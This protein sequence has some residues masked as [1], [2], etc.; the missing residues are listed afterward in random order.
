MRE[1]IEK[2]LDKKDAE[3]VLKAVD[4]VIESFGHPN[5]KNKT[6]GDWRISLPYQMDDYRPDDALSYIH[7]KEMLKSGAIRFVLEM[8]RAQIISPFRNKRSTQVVCEDEELQQLI[9]K[10]LERILPQ[11]M[12]EASWSSL[13]YGSAFMEKVWENKTKKYMGLGDDTTYVTVPKVPNLVPHESVIHITRTKDGSFDGFIQRSNT[14]YSLRSVIKKV[15]INDLLPT[16]IVVPVEEAIVIPYNG[17]SRNLW[18]ESF[19]KPL[20]PLWFWHELLI[21]SM[22]LFGEMMGDPPRFGRAPSRKK[23]KISENTYVNAMDH[24]LNLSVDLPQTN[25]IVVPSDTDDKGTYEWELGYMQIPDRSQ[26]FVNMID[27]FN[28]MLI[29]AGITGDASIAQTA[30]AGSYAIGEVHANATQLHNDM[31]L[32][33]WVHYLNEYLI[34]DIAFYNAGPDHPMAMLEVKSLDPR[35]REYL[36]GIMA[37]AGNSA[38]FQEWFYMVDWETLSKSAGLPVLSKEQADEL[39]NKLSEEA[40]TRQRDQMQMMKDMAPEQKADVADAGGTVKDAENQKLENVLDNLDALPILYNTV[41]LE[42]TI[43]LKS[44]GKKKHSGGD[45]YK[46]D[47]RGRF[48]KKVGAA[49]GVGAAVTIALLNREEN[50][51]QAGDS[52]QD[53][54]DKGIINPD[55]AADLNNF[56]PELTIDSKANTT[57]EGIEQLNGLPVF[58]SAEDAVNFYAAD[59]RKMGLDVPNDITVKVDDTGMLAKNGAAAAYLPNS[60][61]LMMTQ[62]Q[63]DSLTTANTDLGAQHALIHEILHSTQDVSTNVFN[64]VYSISEDDRALVEGVNELT[65]KMYANTKFGGIDEGLTGVYYDEVSTMAGVVDYISTSTGQSPQDVTLEM[66]DKTMDFYDTSTYL[67]TYFPD[68]ETGKSPSQQ[69]LDQWLKDAG[70]DKD[71]AFEELLG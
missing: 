70:V 3:T 30:S 28:K 6:M 43:E 65:T 35:E 50:K 12:F 61:T 64:N 2:N 46:R 69:Q 17:F 31:V 45:K 8:K 41:D 38:S 24:L 29:R 9:E 57:F 58:G 67:K 59:F 11:M 4:L 26:P 68:V 55:V 23:V 56:K 62:E 60:N 52:V 63:V 32:S 40:L 10:V 1:I 20:Y 5:M 25:S 54:I 34:P 37:I 21:R 19:L 42:D 49:I 7:I 14:T 16:D 66:Q 47:G 48:A 15:T 22:V 18:G 51:V 53:L 27:L 33:T 36:Q 39:K 71:A 13:V 44:K